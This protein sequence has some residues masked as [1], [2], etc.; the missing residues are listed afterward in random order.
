M[1]R[2]GTRVTKFQVDQDHPTSDQ[3][4]LAPS[5]K[6]SERVGSKNSNE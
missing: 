6:Q 2:M 3:A 5:Y 1:I 4:M